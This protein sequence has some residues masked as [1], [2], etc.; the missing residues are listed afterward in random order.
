MPGRLGRSAQGDFSEA[1][2]AV[3]V[4]AS[5]AIVESAPAWCAASKP[6][7]TVPP[8]PALVSLGAF[9]AQLSSRACHCATWPKSALLSRLQSIFARPQL[10]VLIPAPAPLWGLS[11]LL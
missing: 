9:S 3:A 11:S 10:P 7:S 4:F 2:R 1:H 5:P 6:Q 8:G